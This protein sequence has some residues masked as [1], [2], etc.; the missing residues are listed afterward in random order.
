M[1]VGPRQTRALVERVGRCELLQPEYHSN[2]SSH[3]VHPVREGILSSGKPF[4]LHHGGKL[5]TLEIGWRCVGDPSHPILVALGGISAHR[6]V[7]DQSDPDSGWWRTIV[8]PGLPVPSD[9][10]QILSFDYLGGSGHTSGPRD[11][12]VFPS[13]STVDQAELLNRIMGH[14]EIESIHAF[15]GASYGGMVGLAFAAHYPQLLQRLIVLSAA[16]RTHPMA[17][18]W[19]S[20][21]RRIV[22]LGDRLGDT[23]SA[24][25]LA[26]G[27]AMSTYRS[28]E[29]FLQRFNGNARHTADGAVFPVEE[30]LMSRGE[31][32]AA[33]YSAGSFVTLSESIDLHRIDPSRIAVPVSALAVSSDQLVPLADMQ[34]LATMLPNGRLTQI[35]SIFGHDAFLKE[36]QPLHSFFDQS[37]R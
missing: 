18:A 16:H 8:G 4:S 20:V 32:Y 6:V 14:L 36:P 34:M 2:M 7:C 21:Q 13:V 31:Q 17:T 29:E 22:R 3:K 30:Y 26:R 12:L 28:P 24:L 11:S 27:L 23:R 10:F 9:R 19:R 33:R 37:L 1:A 25:A 35:D 5:A 15:V